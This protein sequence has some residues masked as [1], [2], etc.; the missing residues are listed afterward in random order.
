MSKW[1]IYL[2]RTKN[3][4][5]NNFQEVIDTVKQVFP[6]EMGYDYWILLC[7][8][9][10]SL[11][12]YDE[13]DEAI[14]NAIHINNTKSRAW[15]LKAKVSIGLNNYKK[16]LRASKRALSIE[17]NSEYERLYL[18]ICN[19][20]GIK[21]GENSNKN[22]QLHSFNYPKKINNMVFLTNSD[23]IHLLN[24]KKMSN[25][26]YRNM[27]D[28]IVEMPINKLCDSTQDIFYKIE[29]FTR[30][31]VNINYSSLDEKQGSYI[32]NNV[33]IDDS[34]NDSFKIATL[35]HE[36]AHHLLSEIFEQVVMYVFD[37]RKTDI[38]EAFA[39]YALFYKDEY[40]LLNEYC[41]HVVECYFM[42][43]NQGNYESFNKLL[44][45]YDLS[46][47]DDLKIIDDAIILGNTFA[48]DI[49]YMLE[50]FISPKL[51]DEIKIQYVKDGL[52][53]TYQLGTEF[54]TNEKY[55][56]N[57]K[58]SLIHSILTDA[59]INIK[60][61]FSYADIYAFKDSFKNA[62]KNR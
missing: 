49:I 1:D 26:V 18:M 43:Y 5:N 39:Y 48:L 31:F 16:A 20:L 19:E 11:N 21:V 28:Y 35:I 52:H 33:T 37:S 40:I 62:N 59:L 50:K 41:A 55:S 32:F 2:N 56:E 46:N 45:N 38:I 10:L 61:T 9:N 14:S 4:Y 17:K 24:E 30:C 51:K 34:L 29:E 54:K 25:V 36:L 58:I 3:F 47:S 23:N 13:A 42:P 44:D 7:E 8:L 22:S 57:A 15:Y 27:L 6:N 60:T 12:K 53:N